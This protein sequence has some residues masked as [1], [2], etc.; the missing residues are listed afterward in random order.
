MTYGCR[1]H[2]RLHSAWAHLGNERLAGSQ[3]DDGGG[4]HLF[5]EWQAQ[6]SGLVWGDPDEGVWRSVDHSGIVK[7]RDGCRDQCAP[8]T[9]DDRSG[10][11]TLHV[12]TEHHIGPN[13]R[14]SK[15]PSVDDI[16]ALKDSHE[17]RDGDR[18]K[19]G[20]LH[21]MFFGAWPHFKTCVSARGALAQ[22]H[23]RNDA[24]GHA[25]CSVPGGGGDGA[26]EVDPRACEEMDG[27][28]EDVTTRCDEDAQL[29]LS[30]NAV[31]LAFR[32]L[33]WKDMLP[34][35]AARACTG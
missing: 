14:F 22:S 31:S 11:A 29:L 4:T 35:L 20:R 6:P 10:H 27:S 24:R 30:R 2:Q 7:Q 1:Q 12:E 32:E 13:W 8:D 18:Q 3:L 33:R 23:N 26:N 17:I 21:R 5:V 9:S 15:D 25:M 19:L 16:S 34:E 28:A